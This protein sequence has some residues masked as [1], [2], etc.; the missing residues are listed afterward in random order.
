[1]EH[2]YWPSTKPQ[3]SPGN[4][5]SNNN[6]DN[7]YSDD[8]DSSISSRD[9]RRQ[10]I[11]TKP[12]KSDVLNH[13]KNAS[14]SSNSSNRSMN[15]NGRNS[16]GVYFT[17]RP[18][19]TKSTQKYNQNKKKNGTNGHNYN[20]HPIVDQPFHRQ[21]TFSNDSHLNHSKPSPTILRRLSFKE[22]EADNTNSE[23]PSPVLPLHRTSGS[24]TGLHECCGE[25][26]GEDDTEGWKKVMEMLARNPNAASERQDALYGWTPLHIACLG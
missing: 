23:P 2:N 18:P 3:S 24:F 4:Q 11:K 12:Y 9:G 7:F 13:Y 5:L 25:A 15:N 26:F 10:Q 22:R 1:M 21:Q 14:P 20:H 6:D 8:K 17:I 16:Q 19:V